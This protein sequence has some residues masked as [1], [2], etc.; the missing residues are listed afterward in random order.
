MRREEAA[1]E[2]QGSLFG[3]DQLTETRGLVI[4]SRADRPLTKAQRL[5]NRLVAKIEELRAG[6]DREMHRLD[7]A[8]AYYGEHLHPRLQRYAA[9]RKDFVRAIAP[10]LD[11]LKRRRDRGVLEMLVA[12]QLNAIVAVDGP[13]SDDDL[14]RIFE[15]V[16]GIG[17]ETARKQELDETRSMME[18]V[19][20]EIGVDVDLSGLHPDMSDEA[21]A[22]KAAEVAE[23]LRQKAE[24]E[25]DPFRRPQ[26]RKT[27]RQM[28][29][30][31]RARQAEEF[32]NKSL[33]SIYKRLARALHPDLEPDEGKRERKSGLMQELTAAY[34]NN[35]LHTMLRLELDW[36]QREEGDLERLTEEKL[37]AY[38]Q[39]L[40]EQVDDLQS[41]L[42][43]LP[44]LP[45]YEPLVEEGLFGRRLR[46]NGAAEAR[47]LDAEIAEIE[48]NIVRLRSKAAMDTVLHAIRKYR[49]RFDTDGLPF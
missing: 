20:E 46:T 15:R 43:Q 3:A 24:E 30:E 5:F 49:R 27:K 22:A 32:R 41:K 40:K 28:E 19:F 16:H 7:R 35:D 4:V 6:L 42:D 13:L 36:I 14:K 39:V 37:S 31:Q 48:A 44:D 38:N 17:F 9:L 21:M 1:M 23:K 33:S 34:R 12:D 8:L 2:K 11:Q 29:R 47:Q 26:R 10:F 45:R 25:D 18:D